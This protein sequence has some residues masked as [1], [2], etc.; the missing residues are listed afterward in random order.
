VS[1]VV[2]NQHEKATPTALHFDPSLRAA[3]HGPSSEPASILREALPL[4][5]RGRV[6]DVAAGKGANAIFLAS[7]GWHVT[8]IDISNEALDHAFYS[9]HEHHISAV[10]TSAPDWIS[11]E[12][13]VKTPGEAR[14]PPPTGKRSIDHTAAGKYLTLV[15]MDFET[16]QLLVGE[17]Q[18]VLC[19]RYLQRSL[20][21]LL[22]RAL[23]P[24]GILIYETYTTDHLQFGTQPRNPE[25]LLHLGELR[26]AFPLLEPIFYRE[27][28][29]G[30]GVATLI[31]A[32]P[33]PLGSKRG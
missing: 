25:Y 12:S 32:R 29:A 9:A 2:K 13:R 18:V 7:H 1:F 24:G 26:Q 30:E 20:F 22:E 28:T 10:K 11:K 14:L 16:R 6:L 31:A 3:G 33:A 4:L 27:F 17:F 8:A 23:R 15:Q 19:F 5:P 21:P